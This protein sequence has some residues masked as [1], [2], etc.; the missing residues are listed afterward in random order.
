MRGEDG[1][2]FRACLAS[3]LEVPESADPDFPEANLDPGVN[4]FLRKHGMRYTRR[5]IDAAKPSGWHTIEGISPRGGMHAVVGR[6]GEF[7]HDPHPQDG[8]G[9]GLVTPMFWGALERVARTKDARGTRPG[10]VHHG[11][12]AFTIQVTEKDGR[13]HIEPVSVLRGYDTFEVTTV[14]MRKVAEAK[15]RDF[16]LRAHHSAVEAE[17]LRREGN[18]ERM[19]KFLQQEAKWLAMAARD[20]ETIYKEYKA[21]GGDAKADEDAKIVAQ[22]FKTGGKSAAV[23]KVRELT[24]GQPAWVARA[25]FE[26]ALYLMI[27]G[28]TREARLARNEAVRT[29]DSTLDIIAILAGIYAWYIAHKEPEVQSYN[30]AKY[31]P[32]RR[33]F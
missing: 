30:L 14:G 13:E 4:K 33:V 12:G 23:S 6:D 31:V 8:T 15:R 7:K 25:L 18:V 29:G 32:K 28:D 5:P 11:K 1:T 3:I 22:A 20:D 24:D 26:K 2:C 16:K 10:D 19:K 27:P 21:Q 9:R 17:E